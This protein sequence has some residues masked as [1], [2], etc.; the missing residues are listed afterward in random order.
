MLGQAFAYFRRDENGERMFL[1]GAILSFSVAI[2]LELA[3]L[4]TTLVAAV[5]AVALAG[6][7]ARVLV[8]SADGETTPPAISFS[9]RLF[10]DGLLAVVVAGVYLLVPTV[11]LLITVGGAMATDVSA[12]LAFPTSMGIYAG[13]VAALLVALVFAYLAPVAVVLA[14]QRRS[15]RAGFSLAVIWAVVGHA[16]YFYAWTL[17]LTLVTVGAFASSGL[18]EIPVV[19]PVLAV[20]VGFYI[21]ATAT[22]LVGRGCARAMGKSLA[23][24]S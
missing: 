5:P 14:V 10:R 11:V 17:A 16:A 12:P 20:F 19:G 21:L 7:V 3:T 15:L 23:R 24:T 4:V 8:S 18:A 9:T 2:L 6:Y 13:S 1:F 22:H